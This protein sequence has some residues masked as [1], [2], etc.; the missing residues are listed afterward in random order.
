MTR[1]IMSSRIQWM[2]YVALMEENR[3]VY[4]ALMRKSEDK[5]YMAR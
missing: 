3:I 5:A 2:G 1:V 4:S